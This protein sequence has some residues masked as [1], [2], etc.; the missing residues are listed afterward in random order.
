MGANMR[1]TI[2]VTLA[3]VAGLAASPRGVSAQAKEL[4]CQAYATFDKS[5]SITELIG[6]ALG[7]I[8]SGSKVK[9]SCAGSGCPFSAK[10]F[11]M[12]NDVKTLALTDM[13]RDP[14]L[15]PGMVLEMRVTK[16]GWIGKSFQYEI[17][18]AGD[19][20]VTEKCVSEDGSTTM[21]CEK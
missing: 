21:V 16:P 17:R 10:E 13:F 9:L 3:I 8:P 12:K 11:T 19:P 4:P 15:K 6:L 7:D 2:L 20:K 1:N 14:N 18:A 5:G